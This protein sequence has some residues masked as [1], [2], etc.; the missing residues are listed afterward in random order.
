MNV[1][2]PSCLFVAVEGAET[3]VLSRL[4]QFKVK[5]NCMEFSSCNI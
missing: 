3:R 2:L 4:E 1:T 5:F